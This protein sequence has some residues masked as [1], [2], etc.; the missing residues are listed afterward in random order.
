[1]SEINI[2]VPQ[3][4]IREARLG[5]ITGFKGTADELVKC[6]HSGKLKDCARKFSQCMG[7]SSGNAFCQLS[8]IKDAVVINHGPIG[9]AG[10]FFNFN[11]VYRVGQMERNLQPSIGRYFNTN[12]EESDTV[13]GAIRK[14]EDTVRAAYERV[15]PNAIF[16]TTSCAS[17]II[18]DDVEGVANDLTEELG[19]PVVSCFCEG[20]KS[21]LWTTGFDSAY[22]SIVRKIVKQP[23]NKTNKVNIVNFWGSHIFDELLERLGYKAEYIVPFSTVADL[24][25]ISEAAA[26]IQI[27]PTLGTYLGAALE[28]IY[29]V[30]EIKSPP[31]YGIKGTDS[32]LRE[33]GKVLDREHEVEEIIKEEHERITPKINEFRQKLAGKT[34]YITAGAAHGHAIIALL[35]EL[36]LEVQGAAIFH[37]DPVYDNGDN[38]SDALSHTVNTYGDVKNYNVCNKQA[39]E[40]VNILNR[41]RPDIMIARHGGMTVWGAKLGVPTLLIGD[42][43]FGFGYQGVLNY[44][45]R[46]IETLDNKE[47][48]TNLAKHSSMPYTKWWLEQDPFTFLGGDAHVEV[49]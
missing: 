24:E 4:R 14:L 12:I 15:K 9:C 26:T 10:D 22:H 27:C 37:H 30:P 44:A 3:V 49:Y 18:G 40:L 45:E 36:G 5:S 13:F 20:F 6:S 31:A 8:M 16:I 35:R 19:I 38:T 42:E 7:C 34:A 32:W 21:K 29:G 2:K 23:R 11:F 28:Q 1:M 39:Y 46:I 17:G 48:V 33:L 25:Y 43:Q 41:V 47:F